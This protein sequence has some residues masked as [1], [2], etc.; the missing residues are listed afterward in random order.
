[1]SAQIDT[2]SITVPGHVVRKNTEGSDSVLIFTGEQAASVLQS[3]TEV[4]SLLPP[5]SKGVLPEGVMQGIVEASTEHPKLT[6]V[7]N[8]KAAE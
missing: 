1:M 8:T 3:L 2:L 5:T 4:A 7:T 6:A